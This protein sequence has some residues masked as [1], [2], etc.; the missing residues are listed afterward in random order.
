MRLAAK[1]FPVI[2]KVAAEL[3][4]S[5]RREP[6]AAGDRRG[7]LADHEVVEDPPV[8]VGAGPAPGREI[9]PER[10]LVWAREFLLRPVRLRVG[11]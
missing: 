10:H 4:D 11:G 5:A 2:V 6:V 1:P 7:P 8:A 3:R 9:V